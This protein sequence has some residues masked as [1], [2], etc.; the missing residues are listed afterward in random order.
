MLIVAAFSIGTQATNV[1]LKREAKFP[2]SG[3]RM[4]S[5]TRVTADYDAGIITLQVT[6]YTGSIQVYVYDSNGNVVSY[7]CSVISGRGAFSINV[8]NLTEGD[9]I[10]SI[11]LDNATYNGEFHA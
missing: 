8:D 1:D 3:V 5:V 4:P 2:K 9:Y 11:V 10:L 7:D 6:G